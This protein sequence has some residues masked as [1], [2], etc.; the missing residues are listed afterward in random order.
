[1]GQLIARL[2]ALALLAVW[3][4]PPIQ[5]CTTIV[6]RDGERVVF[7]TNLDWH[8]AEGLVFVNQRSMSRRSVGDPNINTAAWVSRFGSVTFNVAGRDLPNG[9]IN[10]AGLT[11]GQMW[12]DGTRYPSADDRASL[13]LA[14]WVQYQLDTSAGVSDVIASDRDVRITGPSPSH[15]LVAYRS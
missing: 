1:M 10:E 9:G 4:A 7:G 15:F 5:P 3:S 12:L 6:L 2:A 13:D 8:G 11:I 14:S